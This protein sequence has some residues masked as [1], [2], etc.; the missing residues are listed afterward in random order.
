MR[1]D[2]L[3][4]Q[5]KKTILPRIVKQYNPKA[6]IIFGSRIKGGANLESD[7]DIIIVSKL[8]QKISFMERIHALLRKFE[9]LTHVDYICYTPE[10]FEKIKDTSSLIMDAL[11]Y[12]EIIS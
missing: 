3:V 9:F 10:E 4:S 12:G 8:F 11:E 7:L 1:R 5:F 6:I 2:K